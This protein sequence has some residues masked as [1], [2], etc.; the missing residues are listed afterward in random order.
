M[1]TL[2]IGLAIAGGVV[3]AGVVAH[4]TWT[5]RKNKPRQ[6]EPLPQDKS[7]EPAAYAPDYGQS[8][9]P[10]FDAAPSVSYD[11][12]HEPEVMAQVA[13]PTYQTTGSL[14][15]VTDMA[16]SMMEEATAH[17]QRVPDEAE[18]AQIAQSKA[19]AAKAAAERAAQ[20]AA[21]A[22]ALKP[23]VAQVMESAASDLPQPEKRPALDALIDVIA[24]VEI[25]HPVSGD[26]ALQAMPATR[27]VGSKL[28]SLEGLNT[29]TG[30]WEH[31]RNG[32]RYSAF[33]SGVQLA[34]RT[35]PLNEIEFSE[36][37]TKTQNFADA[38]NGAPEFPDML[39]EVSRARE[40]DH[41]ASA[42]DAQL[43]FTLKA[44][45]AAWSPGY[46]Q[47]NAARLGFIAG[48][49][50]G[51]MVVPAPVHGLP[52]ILLLTF[53]SQAAMSED[54][55]QSAIYELTLSLDVPQVDRK[56]E[57]YARMIQ[58]AYELARVMDGAISD[59]NGQPLSET[60]IGAIAR[61][62]LALYDTL[63]ARDLSAGSP[64]ARRLFS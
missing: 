18:M 54:P 31:P 2:Q 27:R 3:L 9:E 42:H 39:E 49:L 7:I 35:G 32:Q 60:A 16:R 20:Q 58:T 50:P 53:D 11:V 13:T 23:V 38:I 21:Q 25:D 1:S 59:D 55:T 46:V 19:A 15:P 6:A 43:S 24:A 45:K 61:D 51:R 34:N 5:S 40:L 44:T 36:F 30:L 52:P 48:V 57:P 26:A 4:S 17:A 28:F 10:S 56:E 29:E 12:H 33:Q 22:P 47:Q 14:D 64:Q 62:L 41:F 63:D 8:Q 37:V